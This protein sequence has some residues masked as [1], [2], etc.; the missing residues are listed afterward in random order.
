MTRQACDKSSQRKMFTTRQACDESSQRQRFT[1]RQHVTTR[2]RAYGWRVVPCHDSLQK[3]WLTSHTIMTTRHSTC[4]TRKCLC[5][6]PISIIHAYF[7]SFIHFSINL[8]IY[9]S[10]SFTFTTFVLFYLLSKFIQLFKGK[11]VSFPRMDMT[12]HILTHLFIV[13]YLLH[14]Y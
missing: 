7:Y 12:P 1:S 2:D 5:I 8:Y 3:S 10:Y 13:T 11:V 4:F 6:H 9:I 14:T